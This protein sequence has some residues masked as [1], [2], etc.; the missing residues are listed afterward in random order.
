[1]EFHPWM[2]STLCH[3]QDIKWAKAKVYVYSDAVFCGGKIH[4]HSDA[5]ETWKS[6]PKDF[7]QTNEFTDLFGIHGEPIQ[8]ELLISQGFKSLQVLQEIQ[9]DLEARQIYPEQYGGIILFL[10]MTLIGQRKESLQ[11]TFRILLVEPV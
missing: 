3:D 4:D 1:M 7:Q 6:Q 5:N 11:S 2:R 10:S 9:K 8:F